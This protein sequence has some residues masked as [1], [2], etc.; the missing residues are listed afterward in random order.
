MQ[1]TRDINFFARHK[2]IQF[3]DN[4]TLEK[5]AVK[6]GTLGAIIAAIILTVGF[7]SIKS[8][9]LQKEIT[10]INAFLQSPEVLQQFDIVRDKKQEI[11]GMQQYIGAIESATAHIESHPQLDK[12]VLKDIEDRIGGTLVIQSVD[13]SE[14]TVSMECTTADHNDIANFVYSLRKSDYIHEVKYAGYQ[15][16]GDGA[17][18]TAGAINIGGTAEIA[19][20]STDPSS[21]GYTASIEIILKPRGGAKNEVN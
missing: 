11:E 3:R 17:G 9:G 4:K 7:Y 8:Y 15:K 2:E 19:G 20:V 6:I 13:Y 21:K 16:D 18:D 14:G 10:R 12:K 1:Q 5:L